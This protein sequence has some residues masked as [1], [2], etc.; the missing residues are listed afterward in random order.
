MERVNAASGVGAAQLALIVAAF[1]AGLYADVVYELPGQ[2]AVSVLMWLLLHY[3]LER[4]PPEE[5]RLLVLCLVISTAGELLL[6]L[7]W[8][9]YRYRLDNVP[10]FVP[11]YHALL[12]MLGFALARR[13]PDSAA[14]AVLAVAGAY[15]FGAAW[16]GID[17]FGVLLFAL[18]AGCSLWF[19]AR[20]RLF[21]STFVLALALELYGTWLGN[22]T[23][24]P[25]VP[26]L[27]LVTTNP[28]LAAGAFY[29]A[30]DML[31]VAAAS[32]L[33]EPGRSG[34]L[35]ARRFTRA[36]EKSALPLG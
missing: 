32:L 36:G 30:L 18:L 6:S 23:W 1:V 11:P 24:A 7:G 14:L 19:P 5:R 27:P 13:L 25:E 22:W 28:P 34:S 2:I 16:Y 12:L 4:C 33:R 20:R 15:T 3:L 8:G 21:A 9:L 29:S 26:W 31:V 10:M 35:K 17:T